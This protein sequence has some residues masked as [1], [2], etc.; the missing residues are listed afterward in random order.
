MGSIAKRRIGDSQQW[1]KEAIVYQIYPASYV[2]TTGSGVG[3]LNG[4]ASK[5]PY[6]KS[7]GVDVVWLSPIYQ[8]PMNDMGYDISDYRAINP[9]FGTMEDWER[10]QFNISSPNTGNP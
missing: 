5:L 2:D 3:D 7:L 8:S 4:I 10:K 6:I 1:W 9:M